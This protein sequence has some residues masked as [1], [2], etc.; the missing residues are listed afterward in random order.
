MKKDQKKQKEPIEFHRY[1]SDMTKAEKRELEKQKL[2]TM[3]WR[4]K[5]EYIWSYYKP[6]IFG[7]IGAVVLVIIVCQQI[8][9]AKYRTIL[10]VSVIN[11]SLVNE[12]EAVQEQLQKEFGTDDKYDEVSF[13]TTFMFG[14]IETA[15][16]NMVMKFTAV[17][18]AKSMDVLITNE[19][20][21]DHYQEQELFLD[22]STLFTQ[23]ECEQYGI[24]PGTYRLDITDTAWLKNNQ[25]VSYQPVYLTVISNTEHQDKVKEFIK[26]VEEEE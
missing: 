19:E 18:A 14:N 2:G 9:N 10:N 15:D 25:W 7:I 23:E 8:E 12:S 17:V 4:G 22:L 26:A 21:F 3:N 5:L 13:D 11:T 6:L 24:E 20:I 16:Y 1:E